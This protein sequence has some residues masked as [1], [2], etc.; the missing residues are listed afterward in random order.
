MKDVKTKY[1]YIVGR[2]AFHLK[3]ALHDVMEGRLVLTGELCASMVSLHSP[4]DE[5][6]S[7]NSYFFVPMTAEIVRAFQPGGILWVTGI[8]LVMIGLAS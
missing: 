2:D 1:G 4:F 8:H 5:V 3:Q 7:I 6:R